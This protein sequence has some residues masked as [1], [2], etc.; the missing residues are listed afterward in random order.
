MIVLKHSRNR[1]DISPVKYRTKAFGHQ[2]EIV[3][4]PIIDDQGYITTLITLP[5]SDIYSEAFFI[6]NEELSGPWIRTPGK[7][8]AQSVCQ[9]FYELTD[10]APQGFIDIK[11]T[12]QGSGC[13]SSSCDC[14]AVLNLLCKVTNIYLS[15]KT[16]QSLIL[17]VEGASDPL[18]LLSPCCTP[19]CGSRSD[20]IF[21]LLPGLPKFSC[22]GFQWSNVPVETN[23]MNEIY[24]ESEAMQFNEILSMAKDG[25][26]NGCAKT[27]FQAATQSAT[28][29]QKHL[30]TPH[31]T[32]LLRLA[33]ILEAGVSISHSGNVGSLLL[34]D[35]LSPD[36]EEDV[37][38]VLS[39][40][41]NYFNIKT[42]E[43]FS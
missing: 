8:R 5:R 42:F 39:Y 21:D 43:L 28:L 7:K 37:K 14:L 36:D 40:V 13:G 19:V 23:S 33:E 27:I 15:P 4:G 38:G 12:I 41:C 1:S 25:I 18:A 29:A 11:N 20:I 32:E 9:K 17:S 10:C 6:P 24:S 26:I 16:K 34:M 22:L 3:Q 31:F 35:K 30:E 2:G